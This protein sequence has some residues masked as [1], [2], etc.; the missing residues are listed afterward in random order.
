MSRRRKIELVAAGALTLVN[1]IMIHKGVKY[2]EGS[3]DFTRTPFN[4]EEYES[5]YNHYN[6]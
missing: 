1:A 2:Y 4:V 3:K 5:R 6:C